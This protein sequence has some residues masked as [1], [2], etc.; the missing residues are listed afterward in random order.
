MASPDDDRSEARSILKELVVNQY[1]AIILGGTALAS[2]VALNPLPLLLWLGGELV[3]LPLLDSGPL[4]RMVHR[5]RLGRSRKEVESRRSRVISSLGPANQK[6]YADMDH[7]CRLIEANYRTLHGIS[8]AYLSEQRGK[9]DMILDGCAHRM[10]ALERYE[11]L[12]VDRSPGRI[13]R[14]IEGLEEELRDTEQAERARTALERNLEL[15]RRLLRSVAEAEDTIKALATELDSMAS[16]LEVLHQSS[17]SMGDPQAV[18][19]ELDTIVRQSEDSGRVVREMEALLRSDAA[20][21]SA[22]PLPPLPDEP[23]VPPLPAS[24]R[25]RYGGPRQK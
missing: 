20:D 16:L 13:E 9:L 3:M 6:R 25:Q 4:R 8:Q 18:S 12:L 1:Q 19:Q 7:L 15:K 24:R 5:R 14:E 22:A 23:I 11:R 17:I 2:L 10:M 21:W